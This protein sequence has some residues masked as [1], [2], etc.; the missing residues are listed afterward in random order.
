MFYPRYRWGDRR[1]RNAV[2]ESVNA[3][4]RTG[5]PTDSAVDRR[6]TEGAMYGILVAIEYRLGEQT[7][8]DKHRPSR[9]LTAPGGASRFPG[10][11]EG[12]E[13]SKRILRI[14]LGDRAIAYH[15]CFAKVMGGVAGGVWLSQIMYW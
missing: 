12:M 9:S 2:A 15:P 5:H 13:V 6:L 8:I 1:R 4:R 3:G 14:V 7:I 11:E 10:E